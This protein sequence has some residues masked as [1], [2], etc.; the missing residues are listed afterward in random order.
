[1]DFAFFPLALFGWGGV[2]AG[3][4]FGFCRPG[5]GRDSTAMGCSTGVKT[6]WGISG[7]AGGS[8]Y[9]TGI[10]N[11]KLGKFK[12]AIIGLLTIPYGEERKGIV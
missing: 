3:A 9:H 4:V 5:G 12:V 6:T 11:V 1:M 10:P 7:W 8:R 2:G